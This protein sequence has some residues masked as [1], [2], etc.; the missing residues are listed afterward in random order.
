MKQQLL[1]LLSGLKE[2]AIS[3]AQ[4]I[5]FIETYYQHQPTAFKNGDGLDT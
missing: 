2:K 5:E 1:T 4:V 3:F